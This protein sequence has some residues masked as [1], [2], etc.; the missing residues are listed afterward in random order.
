ML[1][2]PAGNAPVR[3]DLAETTI[4]GSLTQVYG[5]KQL[6]TC[7]SKK[8]EKHRLDCYLRHLLATAAGLGLE[9][10][11]VSGVTAEV[12]VLRANLLTVDEAKVHLEE[13]LVPFISGHQQPYLFATEFLNKR[14]S[15][16]GLDDT[17]F[18]AFLDRAFY[19]GQSAFIHDEYLIMEYDGGFFDAPGTCQ[20]LTA[21]INLIYGPV[22]DSF[23]SV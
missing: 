12:S 2:G 11:F 6:V 9:T 15:I 5:N 3:I 14:D 18:D 22:P 7:F 17:G 20:Q 16:A 1:E 21:N 23:Q 19:G 10:Y 8:E 13:L 4:S